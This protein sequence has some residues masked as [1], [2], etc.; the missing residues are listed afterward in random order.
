MQ[1]FITLDEIKYIFNERWLLSILYDFYGDPMIFEIDSAKL[2]G[3]NF[4]FPH[5]QEK[6]T[7]D[8]GDGCTD[9]LTFHKYTDNMIYRI[10]VHGIVKNLCDIEFYRDIGFYRDIKY[11]HVWP[12]YS[13]RSIIQFVHFNSQQAN[14]YA[15]NKKMCGSLFEN[16]GFNLKYNNSS[17][18]RYYFGPK[19][20]QTPSICIDAVTH[21]GSMLRY[22]FIQTEEICLRAVEQNGYALK[23]VKH[24]T[25]CIC[26]AA[27]KQNGFALMHVINKTSRI[28]LTAVTN[29][30]IV[31]KFIPVNLQNIMICLKA[32]EQNGYA[33]QYAK[34]KD[35]V[36]CTAAINQQPRAK[37][38]ADV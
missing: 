7:V 36:I 31:L 21:N 37:K 29:K 23:Y 18:I 19:Y 1:C 12:Y 4:K 6:I 17:R 16:A 15:C 32:V 25:E 26:L 8:W 34:I 11:N 22:I 13:R 20:Y 3:E 28:C 38:Y 10:L 27:V 24:Q 33:L 9:N 30:G 2:H 14:N 5:L 35:N